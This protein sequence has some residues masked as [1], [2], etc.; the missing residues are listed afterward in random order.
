MADLD[1]HTVL[2]WNPKV[3]SRTLDGSAVTLLDSRMISF[4]E[5]GT[6]IWECFQHGATL[7]QVEE[8]VADAFDVSSERAQHDTYA[9][10]A[11]LVARSMLLGPRQ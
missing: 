6:F 1:R 3:S 10:V 9:F 11:N 2:R 4:N 8:R 5:V 7:A